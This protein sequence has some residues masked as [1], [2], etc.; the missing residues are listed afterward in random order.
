M[1]SANKCSVSS[2]S[3][4]SQIP[5]KLE[6]WDWVDKYPCLEQEHVKAVMVRIMTL[7]VSLTVGFIWNTGVPSSQVLL[8]AL[9]KVS[10]LS[11]S[12]QK[13]D[14]SF[15]SYACLVSTS[16]WEW[17]GIYLEKNI[18]SLLR[19]K[20]TEKGIKDKPKWKQSTLVINVIIYPPTNGTHIAICSITVDNKLVYPFLTC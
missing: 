12:S 17:S 8:W 9:K 6:G 14:S 10:L 11:T 16:G 7:T 19:K 2:F 13:T 5:I 3:A 4:T 15:C 1:T 18:W 20:V